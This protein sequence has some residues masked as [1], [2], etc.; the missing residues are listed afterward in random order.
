VHVKSIR[1][2]WDVD[3]ES[4][5]FCTILHVSSLVVHAIRSNP[6]ASIGNAFLVGQ[7]FTEH[8]LCAE[9]L[10]ALRGPWVHALKADWEMLD[11][12]MVLKADC[13]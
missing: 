11:P 12:I 8:Q 1:V 2:E 7:S 4:L 6:L 13:P 3:Q 10:I 5:A 9:M